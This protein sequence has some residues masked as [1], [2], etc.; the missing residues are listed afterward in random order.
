MSLGLERAGMK[1]AAFCEIE[2]YCQK[3]LAKHWPSV[4]LFQ[5]VT[6]LSKKDLDA[7][8]I[9]VD[10]LCGGFPC[11]DISGAARQTRAG[12]DGERS[13]LF[14]EILRIV[15]E[16][17]EVGE[18]IP[19][20]LLENVP[21]LRLHGADTVISSLESEGYTCW[22][23]VVGAW[24]VDAPHKRDRVWIVCHAASQR[25]SDRSGAQMGKSQTFAQPQ[26]PSRWPIEP[27][28]CRV[29][30][31]IPK[32]VDRLT[33]LGNAVVPAIPELIG[34]WIMQTEAEHG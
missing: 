29:A 6:N 33:A 3:I 17:G 22:P 8:G 23:T 1:T 5:D 7:R 21:N 9:T 16:Y 25:L 19:W 11:Q 12:L 26:R 31:G 18:R 30:N 13:G 34:R 32:R 2:L 27:S 28:I 10:L 15:R 20:L 24:A 4:P 14:F